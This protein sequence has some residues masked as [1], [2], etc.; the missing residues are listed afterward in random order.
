MADVLIKGLQLPDNVDTVCRI[1]SENGGWYMYICLS[2]Y[3]EKEEWQRLELTQLPSH[4]RLIDERNAL[5]A[6]RKGAPTQ[7]SVDGLSKIL[8]DVPTIIPASK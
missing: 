5:E 8:F 2:Q 4:G 3:G 1:A 7:I 6:V